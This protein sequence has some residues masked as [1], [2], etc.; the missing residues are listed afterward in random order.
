MTELLMLRHAQTASNLAHRYLGVTDE[1]LCAQGIEQA[2]HL[3]LPQVQ[4]VFLS[5]LSRCIQTAS[6]IFPQAEQI[7]VDGL[8][9]CDF[10]EFEGKNYLEL[11][12]DSRYQSW[13]NSGGELPFPGGESRSEFCARTCLAF[14]EILPHLMREEQTALIAH[15]GTLMALLE[16]YGKPS[17]G[18]FDWQV[19]NCSGFLVHLQAGKRMILHVLE[20]LSC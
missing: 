12:S 18:Y 16:R 3:I 1:P 15:G 20:E 2:K 6:L 9:E 17:R 14:E 10:G 4:K 13:I 8:R 5:P 7:P 19:K 11:S